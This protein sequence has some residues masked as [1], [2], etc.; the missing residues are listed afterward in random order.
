MTS[1]RDRPN[2]AL[3]VVDVQNDVVANTYDRDE[4]ITRRRRKRRPVLFRRSRRVPL[5][6]RRSIR[7]S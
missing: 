5:P 4:V 1:L 7:R 3:V 6:K 2:T